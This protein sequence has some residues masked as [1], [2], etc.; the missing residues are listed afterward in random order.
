MNQYQ[1][2][3]KGL[4]DEYVH[5]VYGITKSFPREELYGV[6]SQFRRSAMSVV[7]NYVEGFARFRTAVK[8]NFLEI[9]YGSLKESLYLFDFSFIEKYISFDDYQKGKKLADEVGALLWL[10]VDYFQKKSKK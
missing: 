1:E 2:K 3:L 9:S 8:L 4:M 10:E 5:L 6:V 7:L